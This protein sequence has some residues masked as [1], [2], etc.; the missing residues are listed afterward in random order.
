VTDQERATSGRV[1]NS[2]EV[3]PNETNF[4]PPEIVAQFDGTPDCVAIEYVDGDPQHVIGW[5][6]CGRSLNLYARWNNCFDSNCLT[7]NPGNGYESRAD[8]SWCVF[9]G[10][11]TC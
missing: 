11:P 1:V 10:F 3:R 6:N 8:A 4:L 7:I 9:D 5:N 2:T